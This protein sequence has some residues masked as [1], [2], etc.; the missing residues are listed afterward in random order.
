[1]D[2]IRFTE[3]LFPTINQQKFVEFPSK[4]LRDVLSKKGEIFELS[5]FESSEEGRNRLNFILSNGKRSEM[6]S[7][8]PMKDFML[9]KNSN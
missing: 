6:K 4:E 3:T 5:G 8:F 9:P 2:N 7:E 1:L